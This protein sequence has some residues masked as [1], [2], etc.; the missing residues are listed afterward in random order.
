MLHLIRIWSNQFW[1]HLLEKGFPKPQSGLG[2]F[3]LVLRLCW[4]NLFLYISSKGLPTPEEDTVFYSLLYSRTLTQCFKIIN[5]WLLTNQR[6]VFGWFSRSFPFLQLA[7]F[8]LHPKLDQSQILL[9]HDQ[10]PCISY[11][12]SL[13]HLFKNTGCLLCLRHWVRHRL[14]NGETKHTF[15]FLFGVN[16]LHRKL[17]L[18]Q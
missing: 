10:R 16:C 15:L 3:I 12:C 8:L 17:S 6:W 1:G 5:N 13:I 18:H 4:N 14:F 11:T 2:C 9:T 7:F